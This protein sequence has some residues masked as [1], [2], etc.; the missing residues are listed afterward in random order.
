MGKI[1][2]LSLKWQ[3]WMLNFDFAIFW[4]KYKCD[5][6]VLYEVIHLGKQFWRLQFGRGQ[7][8]QFRSWLVAW[9][10]PG[11]YLNWSWHIINWTIGNKAQ[12]KTKQ[13]SKD[14]VNMKMSSTRWQSFC[15]A[16]PLA[17]GVYLPV[18]VVTL[19]NSSLTHWGRVPYWGRAPYWGRTWHQTR[20]SLVQMMACRL[21]GT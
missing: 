1:N 17:G 2:H 12:R 7:A 15:I 19:Y 14:E 3:W 13:F 8:C 9:S 21:I 10:S 4:L 5:C 6:L 16:A 18:G 11:P 20:P